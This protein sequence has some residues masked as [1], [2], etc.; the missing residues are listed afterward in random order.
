MFLCAVALLLCSQSLRADDLLDEGAQLQRQGKLQEALELFSG[1]AEV[2]DPVG[3][4]GMGVLYFQGTGVPKDMVQSTGWFQIAAEKGYAPAQYN[5]GNAYLHGRG[6]GK[7]L[8][9]AELWWRKSAQQDYTRAQFNLGALLHGN[10]TTP[11]MHEEGIAWIRAAAERGFAKS[12][13]KLDAIGEP[14]DYAGIEPDPGREPL[15]SEARLMTFDP[16]GFTMQ[17]FSGSKPGSAEKY[18]AGRQLEGLA[19]R[20]RFVR[21]KE[22]WT[23]VVNG[24]Y[25]TRGQ[26]RSAID[27]LKPELRNAKPWIRSLADVQG[28]IQQ[29]WRR[30]EAAAP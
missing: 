19:L 21:G 5:L 13:E 11:A 7:D 12:L 25:A 20:F 8:D 2:G 4:Y 1:T 16:Q 9:Q 22:R 17:L 6:I 29:V 24:E 14:V 18:I 30:E 3:A 15:R 23:A 26:A 28:K 27:S 10:G